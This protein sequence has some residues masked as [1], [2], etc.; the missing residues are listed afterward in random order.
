MKDFIHGKW[1][2]HLCKYPDNFFGLGIVDVPYG[3]GE[4]GRKTESRAGYVRQKNGSKIYQ[5]AP[6]YYKAAGYDDQQP[7][8][9]YFDELFRITKH[10]IIW[11]CNYL[12][13]D[14]KPQSSGRIVWDKVNHNSDQSDCEIAWTSLFNSVRQI[15]F[16]WSGFNQG[17]S[18]RE[19]RTSQGNKKLNEKKIHPNQKPVLLYH[20]LV[21]LKQVEKDWILLDTH[22]GSASSLIAFEL[23][24]FDYVAFEK[25]EIFYLEAKKRMEKRLKEPLFENYN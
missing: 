2:D 16:M 13:F 22:T 19:G 7:D 23:N 17:K 25:E 5:P 3:I 18:L 9:A 12:N 14:Q 15:E 8:Q 6:G 21:N 1:E 20:W 11:G 4:D 10:Q 24:G